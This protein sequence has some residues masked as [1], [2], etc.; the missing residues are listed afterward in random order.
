MRNVYLPPLVV[1]IAV[2]DSA[3]PAGPFFLGRRRAKQKK[4]HDEA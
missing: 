1:Y 3:A 2:P 4:E